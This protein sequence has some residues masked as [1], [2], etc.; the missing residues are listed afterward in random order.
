MDNLKTV[1]PHTSYGGGGG[2]GTEYPE[3]RGVG[4]VTGNKRSLFLPKQTHSPCLL[5]VDLYW[6]Y[7]GIIIQQNINVIKISK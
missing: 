5:Y 1:Y 4:R 6:I 3:P 7:Q 2:T